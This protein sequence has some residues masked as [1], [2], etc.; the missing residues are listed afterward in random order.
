MTR[1]ACARSPPP[2]TVA[3]HARHAVFC[4][5]APGCSRSLSR[6]RRR[7]GPSRAT[8]SA[9]TYQG[10]DRRAERVSV[11]IDGRRRTCVGVRCRGVGFLYAGW[12]C[13]TSIAAHAGVR[14]A[15]WAADDDIDARPVTDGSVVQADGGAGATSS[16]GRPTRTRLPARTDDDRVNGLAGNDTLDGGPGERL[17][18]RRPGQRH[19]S[20]ART[21]TRGSPASGATRFT[22]AATA[23]TRSTTA[24][25]RAPVTITLQRRGRRR[26]GRRGRQRRRRRRGGD[27]RRRA[28]TGSSAT[29]SA[30][31]CT[32][33]PATTRSPAARARTASRATRA[34]TRSTR[35]TAATTRST[36]GRATTSSTPTPAT[37]TDELRGRARPRRRRLP[38]RRRLRARRPRDPPGRGR[39]RRQQRRRGLRGRPAVPARRLAGR[40][41]RP[42]A[43]QEPRRVHQARRSAR[44]SAGDTIE[45]RCTAARARA[46]RSRRRRR[47]GKAGRRTVNLAARC[48]KKRYLK[49]K[50]R[51]SRSA[52][53]APNEIGR[54]RRLTVGKRGAIKS[55]PL[56]LAPGAT[57]PSRCS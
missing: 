40:L 6:P 30:T 46:A 5:W 32:A 28:T 47:P 48:F 29:T 34:T 16:T 44:S 9:I 3:P 10:T 15:R 20:A 53:R 39:D 21:T 27:R 42:S 11:G 25:A 23:T 8:S 17:R 19:V 45:V 57:K 56:C 52:S 43:T 54:V 4:S 13:C 1:G 31:A 50:A 18:R 7:R 22:P 55:E 37:R 14:S 12:A 41:Q 24:A 35:A 49:R 38:Q 2:D 33:A 36:A 26:R 51:W